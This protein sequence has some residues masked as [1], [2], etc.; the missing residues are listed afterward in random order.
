MKKTL[1]INR[2]NTQIDPNQ[3]SWSQ[4]IVSHFISIKSTIIEKLKVIRLYNQINFFTFLFNDF[5]LVI[6]QTFLDNFLA[7]S[8]RSSLIVAKFNFNY[9]LSGSRN[10]KAWRRKQN[11]HC[12]RSQTIILVRIESFR[13]EMKRRTHYIEMVRVFRTMDFQIENN[14]FSAF[15]NLTPRPIMFVHWLF[16]RYIILAC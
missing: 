4:H 13:S 16:G 3:D 6:F 12:Q 9:V 14:R 11:Q 10:E 15:L 2:Q 1:K 8:E 5:S 7:N